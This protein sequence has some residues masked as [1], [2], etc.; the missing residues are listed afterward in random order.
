MKKLM[1]GLSLCVVLLLSSCG[2]TKNVFDEGIPLEETANLEFGPEWTVKT[3][4]GI[5]VELKKAALDMG[6]TGFTIPSGDTELVMDLRADYT[7]PYY[8][9][10]IYTAENIV[11]NFDF[12]AGHSYFIQ[13]WGY[14]DFPTGLRIDDLQGTT[15]FK[16]AMAKDLSGA[17]YFI[18]MKF[19]K[20]D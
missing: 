10:N 5:N 17:L 13:F 12:Q 20:V 4:N 1:I 6:L 15:P 14:T 18:E 19:E 11:V 3:Y 9:G 7:Q 8:G 16:L 2:T